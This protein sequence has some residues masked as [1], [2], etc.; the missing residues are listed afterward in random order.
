MATSL[1]KMNYST[2]IIYK[3]LNF[4]CEHISLTKIIIF[5]KI[6]DA[7]P[8]FSEPDLGTFLLP[9]ETIPK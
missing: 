3:Q 1:H 5:D 6:E 7:L 8:H 9:T 2:T 4:Y